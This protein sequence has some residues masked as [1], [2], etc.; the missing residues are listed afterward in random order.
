[1]IL[2]ET[3]YTY[4][5]F[6]K[7]LSSSERDLMLKMFE[8]M[9]DDNLVYLYQ[10]VSRRDNRRYIDKISEELDITIKRVQNMLSAIVGKQSTDRYF[11]YRTKSGING[12]YF[13]NPYL[14]IK[15]SIF[16]DVIYKNIIPK[17][18][19]EARLTHMW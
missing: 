19:V 13:I 12:E 9:T 14:A 2:N 4:G 5:D 17:L 11:M 7:L 10:T 16:N 8:I 18:E 6:S 15:G 3:G 1:M